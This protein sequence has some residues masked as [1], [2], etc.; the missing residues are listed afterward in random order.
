LELPG[1]DAGPAPEGAATGPTAANWLGYAL[2]AARRRRLLALVIFLA[3]AV[4]ALA[5]YRL[6]TPMYQAETRIMVQNQGFAALGRGRPQDDTPTRSVFDLIHRRENLV[7]LLK[8]AGVA[9]ELGSTASTDGLWA[10]LTGGATPEDPEE[11]MIRRLDKA[12]QVTTVDGTI[13]IAIL[14]ARPEQAFK[15]VDGALQNFLEDKHVQ[16]ITMADEAISLLQPRVTATREQVERVSEEVRRAAAEGEAT[17]FARRFVTTAVPGEPNEDLLQLR[18]ALETKERAI[19]DVEEI[20]RRRQTDLQSQLDAQRAVLS[21]AHPTI[22]NLRQD[23]A[24]LTRDSPQISQLRE[25]ARKIRVEYTRIATDPRRKT[26]PQT[27]VTTSPAYRSTGP[28]T[29]VEENERVRQARF[30]HQQMIDRLNVAMLERDAAGAA[31]KYRYVVSWPAELPR[32]PS[33]PSGPKYLVAGL[34]GSLLLALLAVTALE[35]RRGRIVERWQVQR[36][37]GLVVL[38]EQGGS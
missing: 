35:L 18:G 1:N 8:H 20:R 17:R 5:A 27:V 22:I 2:G 15:L 36:Q 29:P 23:L 7:A 12:L 11:A 14:W 37:L 28:A 10:R 13:T 21:D 24:A 31:F 6:S 9:P 33:T 30:Q 4:A 3:G 26:A 32:N 38:A 34:L 19:S 25:E 16:E